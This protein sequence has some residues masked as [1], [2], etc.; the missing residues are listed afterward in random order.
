MANDYE[1]TF[2][3]EDMTDDELYE[4]IRERLRENEHV[5]PEWVE[6]HVR[7]GQVTLGGRLGTDGEVQ[8]AEK[9]VHDVVGYGRYT[10]EIMVD[11]L[12]RQGGRGASEEIDDSAEDDPESQQ[13]D[14]AAHLTDDEDEHDFD[15]EDTM[16][17]TERGIPYVPPSDVRPDGYRSGEEH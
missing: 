11:E 6:I 16:A 8:V 15:T 14:T 5:D 2:D 13:S 17:A 1:S 12:H 7:E 10:S 9:I 4:V 3:S